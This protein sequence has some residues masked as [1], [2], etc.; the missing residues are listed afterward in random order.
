MNSKG[1]TLVGGLRALRFSLTELEFMIQFRPRPG[2][3]Q[4]MLYPLLGPLIQSAPC[5]T[6]KGNNPE[7][8]GEL[9]S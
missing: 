9:V 4:I 3:D 1:R 6:G 2:M 7:H 5:S 8:G